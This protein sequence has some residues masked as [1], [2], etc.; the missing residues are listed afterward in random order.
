MLDKKYKSLSAHFHFSTPFRI[1]HDIYLFELGFKS[2][3]LVVKAEVRF[4]HALVY[5][6]VPN[7]VCAS[8]TGSN[9][10]KTLSISSHHLL[11]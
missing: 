7:I 3:W 9:F 8:E 1:N 10:T 4:M 11:I 6:K 5:I 2:K